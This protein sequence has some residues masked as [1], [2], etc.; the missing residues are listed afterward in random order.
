MPIL[1]SCCFNQGLTIIEV[2][3]H[4][5]FLWYFMSRLPVMM[6]FRHHVFEDIMPYVCTF[7][8]C[9][10]PDQ[11]YGSCEEWFDHELQFHRQEWHCEPCASAFY[12]LRGKIAHFVRQAV[13]QGSNTSRAFIKLT[14]GGTIKCLDPPR[15][16][17]FLRPKTLLALT[18]PHTPQLS[19][20]ATLGITCSS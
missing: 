2:S 18:A 3:F 9:P 7:E 13:V 15:L 19:W 6:W 20:N 5:L 14:L 8:Y 16:R 4:I 17:V 12:K 1:S 10:S 11:L